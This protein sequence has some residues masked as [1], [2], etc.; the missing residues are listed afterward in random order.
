[1]S[2]GICIQEE[3]RTARASLQSYPGLR[4][5]LTELLDTSNVSME[6]KRWYKTLRMRGMNL[7]LCI[8]LMFEDAGTLGAAYA[9]HQWNNK[10]PLDD[11]ERKKKKK[12]KK[13]K[14]AFLCKKLLTEI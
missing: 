10:K 12:K 1:M 2:S 6:R 11:K 3:P 4:C 5:P 7:S 14:I 8:S 13:K 9:I